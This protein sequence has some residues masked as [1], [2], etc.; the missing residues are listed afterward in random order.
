MED[1]GKPLGICSVVWPGTKGFV[2][3]ESLHESSAREAIK[4]MRLMIPW[5]LKWVPVNEMTAVLNIVAQKKPIAEKQW[6][7]IKRGLYKGDL[8]RVELV[9]DSGAK[10]HL[11]T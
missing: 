2:Y 10:V 6:V 9:M 8:G 5:S 11:K 4:G 3:V 7:R 1:K